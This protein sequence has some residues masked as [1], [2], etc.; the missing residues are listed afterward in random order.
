MRSCDSNS[1]TV[2]D[3]VRVEHPTNRGDSWFI[4]EKQAYF[5]GNFTSENRRRLVSGHRQFHDK[6]SASA[7]PAFAAHAAAVA[8]TDGLDQR[9]SQ[10]HTADGLKVGRECRREDQPLLVLETAW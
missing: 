9:Q 5:V 8:P 6:S 4:C 1:V 7:R 2:A 10:A 3:L